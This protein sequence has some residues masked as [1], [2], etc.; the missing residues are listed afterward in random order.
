MYYLVYVP[1]WLISLLP[2]RVLYFF[3]DII[4]GFVYYIFK[5][6]RDIVRSN[7]SLAFPEKT[8]KERL[9]IEKKFYHNMVDTFMESLKFITISKKQIQK[10]STGEYDI[11]ND[12]VTK[13]R[14]VHIM[15][16]HQFNWEYANLL[17][18]MN[19]KIPFVGI[20]MRISN[21]HLD[22][23]FFKFRKQ[24]GTI[25]IS[26]QEF[27]DKSFEVFQH[28]YGM[29]LAADQNPGDPSN[30]YWVNFMGKPAPFVKGPA[31]GAVKYNTAL[32]MVGFHKVKR[33]YYHFTTTLLAEDGSKFT[34]E[35]LTIMYK[36]SLEAIIRED[37]SNYLWSHRRW[38][39][40]WKPE[41]GPVIE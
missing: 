20:Y 34:P 33:G 8:D 24:Y 15:A 35:Q 31:K 5:Y 6:R 12:L 14:N 26:A 19:L 38:K 23:I 25:L 27:R 1:L 7:L 9:A 40:D 29:A 30:A 41:Y 13:G 18:A 11:I 10:R 2:F 22:R 16:G 28:Q 32:V 4:Y 37:P 39:Y 17:Y 3:A 21:K 36:N